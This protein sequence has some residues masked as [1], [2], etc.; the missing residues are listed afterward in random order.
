MDRD[1]SGFRGI[2]YDKG[3]SVV[4]QAL[5]FAVQNLLFGGLGGF[6]PLGD[7]GSCVSSVP[8]WARMSSFVIGCGFCGHGSSKWATTAWIGEGVWTLN[9]EPFTLGHDVCLSQE[10]LCAPEVMTCSIADLRVRQRS[11]HHRTAAW[12]GARAI[13][14]RGSTVGR[15]SVVSGGPAC[16]AMY[17]PECVAAARRIAEVEL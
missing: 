6:L 17:R 2:G 4:S 16:L 5:W 8:P 15:G 13:V 7:R 10:S 1:L 11:H 14:L 9:L 12:V 3:R